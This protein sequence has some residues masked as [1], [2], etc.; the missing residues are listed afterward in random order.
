MIT[1]KLRRVGLTMV[2]LLGAATLAGAQTNPTS[3]ETG[4]PP[5][6]DVKP[7]EG[8]K[9]SLMQAIADA[10]REMRG[11]TLEARF[12][13]WHDQP[14]YLIRTYTNNEVWEVRIDANTGQPI[15][16]PRAIP[17]NELSS[18]LQRDV[19]ALDKVRT[20]VTDAVS[21]AE[22][23]QGGKAIMV[24]VKEQPGGNAA[25]HIE[26]VSHDQLHAAVVDAQSG[27]LR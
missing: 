19:A 26:L 9:L 2:S 8:S 21:K 7:F 22:Q 25:Y 23:Q 4:R 20:S 3:A 17:K 6:A 18:K 14:A 13:V 10:R 24:G 11:E 16:E 12:E 15:G 5:L 27:Q 1:I